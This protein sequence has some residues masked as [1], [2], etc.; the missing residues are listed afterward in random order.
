MPDFLLLSEIGLHLSNHLIVNIF[1][2]IRIFRRENPVWTKA[3]ESGRV[4][5]NYRGVTCLLGLWSC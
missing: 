5:K 3:R 1:S 4:G 2:H